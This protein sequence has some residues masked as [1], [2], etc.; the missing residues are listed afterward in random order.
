[1]KDTIKDDAAYVQRIA[2]GGADPAVQS[3]L[4]RMEVEKDEESTDTVEKLKDISPQ[5]RE[6]MR[7]VFEKLQEERAAG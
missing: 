5:K 1:M 2:N 6:A 7:R 3:L 4:H